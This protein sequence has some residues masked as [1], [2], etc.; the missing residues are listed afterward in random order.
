MKINHWKDLV[1]LTGIVAIVASLVFVGL[2]LKQSQDIAIA[3][4]YQNRAIAAQEYLLWWVDNDQFLRRSVSHVESLYES[5]ESLYESGEGDENFRELFETQG[6]ELLATKMVDD[7]HTLNNFDNFY[8]QYQLGTLE[9]ESWV[10]FRYRLKKHLQDK[11]VR[12]AFIDEPQRWRESFQQLCTELI[13]E[14]DNDAGAT[15]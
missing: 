8:K 14:I 4:Q 2:Q 11:M 9:E 3:E 7:L 12:A 5:G 13:A 1:E 10:A 6:P 15:N